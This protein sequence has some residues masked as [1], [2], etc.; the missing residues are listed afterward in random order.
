MD[1]LICDA[2]VLFLG[3]DHAQNFFVREH[4]DEDV[5]VTVAVIISRCCQ[6]LACVLIECIFDA[7]V[8]TAGDSWTLKD[9]TPP[10]DALRISRL[11]TCSSNLPPVSGFCHAQAPHRDELSVID[12]DSY[13]LTSDAKDPPVEVTSTTF[14]QA[15][16]PPQCKCPP[17]RRPPRETK[18]HRRRASGM[19]PGRLR[20]A[21]PT[22]TPIP[23]PSGQSKMFPATSLPVPGPFHIVTKRVSSL[24]GQPQPPAASTHVASC[25]P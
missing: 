5:A 10:V 14:F 15:A 8:G 9:V 23:L 22:L 1:I 19:S 3:L 4:V 17:S 16:P 11:P 20:T 12:S 6:H 21:S 13:L 24:P 7:S 25:I 2:C 18:P